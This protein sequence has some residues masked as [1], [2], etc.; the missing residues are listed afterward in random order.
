MAKQTSPKKAGRAAFEAHILEGLA[1]PVI[2]IDERRNLVDGNL[3]AFKL[4]GNEARGQDLAAVLDNPKIIKAVDRVLHGKPTQQGEV[5][6]P[7]PVSRTYEMRVQE[8][9]A[10]MPGKPVWVM[11]AL[12]DV[13]VAKMAEKMRADFVSN[14][15]HE[16]RSPLSSLIG[17]IETLRG[18]ARDDPE[19]S[20]RFLS[21]MEAEA[22]RMAR[23]IDD[24]LTL[25]KVETDEHIPPED[26]VDV[27]ALLRRVADSLSVRAQERDIRIRI[28]GA[29]GLPPAV[30]DA[31]EL[32]QLFHNL[33]DNAIT[34]GSQGKAVRV[35]LKHRKTVPGTSVEGVSVAIVNRGEGI[36]AKHLSRLTERFYRVEKGRS[37]SM[38]G[39]GL[40]LAIVKHIVNRHRG[41]LDIES[42]PGKTTTFTVTLPVAG[43]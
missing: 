13:T 4:V 17:F 42:G 34:Y 14:V 41:H 30:G 5:F 36:P 38:G 11:L 25:S 33:L 1:D 9:P 18:P 23:L 7:S 21:I 3:A 19:A 39:T 15:S 6:I 2:L 37:R 10:R 35:A 32:T 40:G 31:D 20:E 24:L 26:T 29:D 16:L 8:L 27:T 12:H 43:H 22:Q 28:A